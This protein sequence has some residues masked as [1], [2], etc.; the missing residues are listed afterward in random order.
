[1]WHIDPAVSDTENQVTGIFLSKYRLVT[2]LIF[3]AHF[4]TVCRFIAASPDVD[5]AT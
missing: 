3:V 2:I 5:A 4:S 1:M